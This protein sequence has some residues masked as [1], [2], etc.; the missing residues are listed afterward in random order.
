MRN[1]LKGH[2]YKSVKDIRHEMLTV[3]VPALF[4]TWKKWWTGSNNNRT[5]QWSRD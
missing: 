1:M 5:E 2:R 4:E 3:G